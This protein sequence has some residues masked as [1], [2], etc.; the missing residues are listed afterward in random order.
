MTRKEQVVLDDRF[1]QLLGQ[2][3]KS[4]SGAMTEF[5]QLLSQVK[6][7]IR[8]N[9]DRD[10]LTVVVHGL[11]ER[12]EALTEARDSY[13]AA[14][15]ELTVEL[16]GLAVLSAESVEIPSET[17]QEKGDPK[18]LPLYELGLSMQ[19]WKRLYRHGVA[20]VSD[21]LLFSESAFLSF[22]GDSTYKEESMLLVQRIK[23]AGYTFPDE[24]VFAEQNLTLS[25]RMYDDFDLRLFNRLK[26]IGVHNG[27]TLL[28]FYQAG[29]YPDGIA[30]VSL[31][32]IKEWLIQHRLLGNA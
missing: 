15:N 17:N 21:A 25:L 27:E 20:N 31:T 14:I 5:K 22:L 8:E 7:Q 30:K 10:A 26:A 9:A 16:V 13:T 28:K 12:I 3:W 23:K 4:G 29:D 18:F 11:A 32:L 19:S 1:L 2:V 6:D 24:S